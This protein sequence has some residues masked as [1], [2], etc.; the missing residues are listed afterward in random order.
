MDVGEQHVCAHDVHR[1]RCDID[2]NGN[3]LPPVVRNLVTNSLLPANARAAI[4][5]AQLPK[6]Q[7]QMTQGARHRWQIA[8][9]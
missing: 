1:W 4:S 8:T 7:Q 5:R 6:W 9:A 2:A 3:P